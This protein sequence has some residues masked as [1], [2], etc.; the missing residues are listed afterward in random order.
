MSSVSLLS[1]L[2]LVCVPAQPLAAA[3]AAVVILP[4]ADLTGRVADS[5]STKPLAGADIVV[6]RDGSIVS[7]ATTDEFGAW[8]VH[9]LAP[10]TYLVE[11][12]MIGFHPT[13]DTVVIDASATEVT[14]NFRLVPEAVSLGEIAVTASPVAVDTRTGNQIFKESDY[15]G[16]PTQTTSQI[17]QQSIAGAARAPTG[18]V[19]IRGQHAE[20]TYYIDGLPVPPG[21]SGSLN[22]LFD[23]SVVDNINFQTGSWDAEFGKRNAAIINV[24]TKVPAG[25]FHMSATGYAGDYASSGETVTLSANSGKFGYFIAGTHQTTDMRREPVVADTNAAGSITG[26]HNY[27]NDGQ[28]LFGFA[29]IQYVA[30]DHDLLNLDINLSRSNFATPFDSAAGIINDRQTDLNHFV[31]LSWQHREVTG[32]HKGSEAFAGVYYRHGALNYVPGAGDDPTFFFYPDTTNAYD[33]AEARSFNL[34]GLKADYLFKASEQLSLKG[35]V[36]LSSTSG[37][38]AFSTADGS[39]APGPFS[40][41]P[42]TGN[43]EAAYLQ[44]V[45]AP[46]EKVEFRVGARYDRHAYPVDSATSATADQISPRFRVSV[47]PSTSTT[48]WAY[49]G[50]L[51]VPTNTE[52]LRPITAAATGGATQTPTVPER[53]NFYELGLT[54]R[55]PG[56]IVMKLSGYRKE[57]SPGIDDTQLPG[58]AITTDVNITEVRIT[59]VEGVFEIRPPGPLS[60]YFNVALNHAY[61]YGAITGAFLQDVPPA[62]PF[63]LDHDQRL[64]SVLGLTWAMHRLL[65]TATGIYGSGLTNGLTPNAAGVAGYDATQ[66]STPVLGTGLFDFNAPFKVDP[67]FIVNASAGVGFTAN[68]M[69]I[70]PQIFV[71]NLLDTKYLLKGAFFSGA[72][73]GR[74]RTF[75]VRLTVGI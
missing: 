38:E 10:A 14:V 17:L 49:Y 12:R 32:A 74:P 65:V 44:S 34:I 50:R 71:D 6:R 29:K 24:Q 72:S 1:I 26:V 16:A 47:F 36:D 67:S 63:D 70:R 33:I 73:L 59:G 46:S 75:N 56:G 66:P 40:N 22:E 9:D 31:N 4:N 42:L 64:S 55:F 15:Q 20:Y 68:G 2:L 43:D 35:G 61:G 30:T 58:S 57:S 27:A 23:P 51:F 7:R 37:R 41:S 11:V 62:E 52:D 19:H 21:I 25:A 69:S 13:A 60:G 3:P 5:A 8:R 18:E 53:D 45:I 54:H 48:L 28:D 39:G